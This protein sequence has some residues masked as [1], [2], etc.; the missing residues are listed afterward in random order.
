[1]LLKMVNTVFLWVMLKLPTS[2]SLNQKRLD[3][4]WRYRTSP[5]HWRIAARFPFISTFPEEE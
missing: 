1:M 4:Q 5:R 3:L 2:F